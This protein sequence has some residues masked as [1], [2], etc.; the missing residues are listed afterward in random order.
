MTL[1]ILLA[2]SY[3]WMRKVLMSCIQAAGECEIEPVECEADALESLDGN[4]SYDV[5]VIY[6]LPGSSGVKLLEIIKGDKKFGT[7]P[8]IFIYENYA[9]EEVER[10]KGIFVDVDFMPDSLTAALAGVATGLNPPTTH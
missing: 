6:L 9:K 5:V 7:I 8:V 10:R 2:V 1:K 4:D 3:V